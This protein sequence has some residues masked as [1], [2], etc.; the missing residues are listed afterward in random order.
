M[1]LGIFAVE[2]TISLLEVMVVPQGQ[3]EMGAMGVRHIKVAEVAQTADLQA[4][5]APEAITV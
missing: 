5:A 2:V 4:P 1:E 3:T